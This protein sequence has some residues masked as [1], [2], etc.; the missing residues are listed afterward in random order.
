[1][2]TPISELECAL[3]DLHESMYQLRNASADLRQSLDNGESDD[4]LTYL[5]HKVNAWC[6][7]V[8]LDRNS[9]QEAMNKFNL[10]SIVEDA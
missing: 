1:M 4:R 7:V 8:K 2:S 10:D 6:A 9:V 5:I 3:K